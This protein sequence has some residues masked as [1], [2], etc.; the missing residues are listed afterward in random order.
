[1]E[2]MRYETGVPPI[3]FGPPFVFAYG[4]QADEADAQALYPA[5]C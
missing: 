4:V 3:E 1:M 2:E 5:G